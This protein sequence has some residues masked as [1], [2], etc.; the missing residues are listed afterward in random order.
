MRK[1]LFSILTLAFTFTLMH[2]SVNAE[3]IS[4]NA[5]E[6][7]VAFSYVILNEE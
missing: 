4:V 1:I 3:N 7:M 6:D 5:D 2:A